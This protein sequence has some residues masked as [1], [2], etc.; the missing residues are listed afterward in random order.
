M[1]KIEFITEVY[2]ERTYN[3]KNY[4]DPFYISTGIGATE[5]ASIEDAIKNLKGHYV[6]FAPNMI[7]KMETH[8]LPQHYTANEL[9]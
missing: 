4:V 8:R 5:D 2:M 7:A 1:D 9:A 6:D 3:Q